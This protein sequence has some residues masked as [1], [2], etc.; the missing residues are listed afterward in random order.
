MSGR[1]HKS[2]SKQK[3]Y[4]IAVIVH[5]RRKQFF[6]DQ[7]NRLQ[8]CVH[9]DFRVMSGHKYK[10]LCEA[11]SACLLHVNARGV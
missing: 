3:Q 10:L 7:A 4:L 6:S 5:G 2:S 1:L 11:Q 9:R 8:R